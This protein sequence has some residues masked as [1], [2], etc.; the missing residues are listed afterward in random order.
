LVN[1]VGLIED[2]LRLP[3]ADSV[4]LLDKP[5]LQRVKLEP[6]SV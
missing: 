4:L 5:V 6:Q 1:D 2:L 3:E